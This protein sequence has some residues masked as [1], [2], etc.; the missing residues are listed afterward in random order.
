[1]DRIESP[2]IHPHLYSRL[3]FDRGHRH[4]QWAKDSL[5]TKWHWDNWTDMCKK[6]KLD[7]SLTPHTRINS[8]WIRDLTVR[9]ETVKILKENRQ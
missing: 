5:F 1:M 6:T 8:K 4:I 7:H 3:I 2:E 9:P